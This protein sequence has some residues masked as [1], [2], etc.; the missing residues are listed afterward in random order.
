MIGSIPLNGNLVSDYL[1]LLIIASVIFVMVAGINAISR[2]KGPRKSDAFVAGIGLLCLGFN[3]WNC[4]HTYNI[5][6]EERV[7]AIEETLGGRLV[8]GDIE[9]GG[10]FVVERPDGSTRL[11][12]ASVTGDSMVFNDNPVSAG[13]S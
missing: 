8:D 3:I 9:R 2:P 13:G 7:T 4:V 5:S 1:V 11:V 12:T 10:F 6:Y